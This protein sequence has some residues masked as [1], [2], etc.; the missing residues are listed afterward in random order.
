MLNEAVDR[1]VEAQWTYEISEKSSLKY[2]NPQS[3][4]AGSA[5]HIYS[6]VRPNIEDVKRAEIKARIL[7]GTYTLQSN[8]AKFNQ[9]QV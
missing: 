6:T 1:H 3:V 5:H 4:K 8:R 7:T 2:L 9:Y